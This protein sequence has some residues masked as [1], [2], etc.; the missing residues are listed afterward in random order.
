MELAR[1]NLPI[2]RFPRTDP[3]ERLPFHQTFE[4]PIDRH[5]RFIDEL[6]HFGNCDIFVLRHGLEDC[7]IQ[8]VLFADHLLLFL[9]VKEILLSLE[10][11]RETQ[12]VVGVS[13]FDATFGAK[14][15]SPVK[16]RAESVDVSVIK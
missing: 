6:G 12:F 4:M 5:R 15:E 11:E 8:Q 3:N 7:A 9:P 2:T 14:R 10:R 1:K 13:V 16:T